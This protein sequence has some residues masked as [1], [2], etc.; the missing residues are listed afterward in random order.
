MPVGSANASQA[1]IALGVAEDLAE[2]L[3]TKSS[4]T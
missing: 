2:V 3:I 4:T 1:R